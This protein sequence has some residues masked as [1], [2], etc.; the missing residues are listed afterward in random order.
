MSFRFSTP[1]NVAR[2]SS[3][4]L[5][6]SGRVAVVE[7]PIQ[8][9]DYHYRNLGLYR[10]PVALPST[11]C[12]TLGKV[13][14]SV[15]RSFTECGTFGTEKHS[16]KIFLPSAKLSGKAALGKKPSAVV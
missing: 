4:H 15:T 14:Y 5:Q 11:F 9:C 8:M 12:R 6:P 10:V 1:R 7:D 3:R 2:H 16:A 13:P